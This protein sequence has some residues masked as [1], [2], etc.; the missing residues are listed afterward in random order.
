MR[1]GGEVGL[2][3]F[4]QEPFQRLHDQMVA[5]T[6]GYLRVLFET[7]AQPGLE[8]DAGGDGR[9]GGTAIATQRVAVTTEV[10]PE[11]GWSNLAGESHFWKGSRRFALSW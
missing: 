6:A 7:A 9:H 3:G 4:I 11:N 10:N 1:F 2:P 5:S 8:A